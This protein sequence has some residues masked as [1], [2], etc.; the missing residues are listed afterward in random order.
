MPLPEVLPADPRYGRRAQRLFDG[1]KFPGRVVVAADA[2]QHAPGFI[3]A[4]NA[5]EPTRALGDK[6]RKQKKQDCRNRDRRKHPAPTELRV[7]GLQQDGRALGNLFRDAPVGDLR[8][9]N[10]ANDGQLIEADEAAAPR[11]GADFGDVERRN[12]GGKADGHSAGDA[13][14]DE[15]G[16]DRSPAGE[17]GGKREQQSR[18][19]QHFFAAQ[20]AARFARDERANETADERATVGPADEL[21]GAEMK[22][23]F[24]KRLG[25][26]DDDPVVAEEQPAHGGNQRHAA[27]VARMNPGR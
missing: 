7:P 23:D 14:H 4:M 15:H 10:A 27:D 20:A 25:A 5:G 11:R 24:V 1:R 22:V 19:Q 3:D 6:K 2:R 16:E 13:P 9:E 12:V 17:N 26:A 8:R 21:L 18:K